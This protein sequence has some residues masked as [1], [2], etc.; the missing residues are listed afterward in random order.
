MHL[1]VRKY[2][3]KPIRQAQYVKSDKSYARTM[4]TRI[5]EQTKHRYIYVKKS[6]T[7][8]ILRIPLYTWK[9]SGPPIR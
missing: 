5:K 6:I 2:V 8:K 1:F 9:W 4:R 7:A 3:D